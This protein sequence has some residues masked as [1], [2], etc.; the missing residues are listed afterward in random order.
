MRLFILKV[1]I[2]HFKVI[3]DNLIKYFEKDDSG[4]AGPSHFITYSLKYSITFLSIDKRPMSKTYTYTY[5]P[6]HKFLL[7]G[8]NFN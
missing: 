1:F 5:L 7:V 3:S 2:A 6:T 4:V 8:V